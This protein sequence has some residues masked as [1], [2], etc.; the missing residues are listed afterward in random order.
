MEGERTRVNR[1]E[2][3]IEGFHARKCRERYL[4]WL[5]SVSKVSQATLTAAVQSHAVDSTRSVCH[6]SNGSSFM[7]PPS[8]HEKSMI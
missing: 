4:S 1:H 7:S 2:V 3:M 5:G 6:S 8:A